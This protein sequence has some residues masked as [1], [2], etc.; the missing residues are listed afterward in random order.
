MTLKSLRFKSVLLFKM[1]TRYER[2]VLLRY[3]YSQKPGTFRLMLGS[4]F[5]SMKTLL[6]GVKSTL[7]RWY[8]WVIQVGPNT[9]EGSKGTWQTPT[10]SLQRTHSRAYLHLQAHFLP[11]QAV[12]SLSIFAVSHVTSRKH[13]FISFWGTGAWCYA[14]LLLVNT[15]SG[16]STPWSK[17]KVGKGKLTDRG[18]N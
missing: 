7:L 13:V 6:H 11:L 9:P 18:Y 14:P 4:L 15:S 10:S 8:S 17:D 16:P 1:Q 3:L 5:S 12:F 2:D